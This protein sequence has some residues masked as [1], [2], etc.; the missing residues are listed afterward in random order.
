MTVRLKAQLTRDREAFK[1]IGLDGEPDDYDVQDVDAA[2]RTLRTQL[3]P[4]KPGG[5]AAKFDEARKAHAAARFYSL[6]PKPC[7]T[8]KGSG[9]REVPS[10]RSFGAPLLMR[11]DTC[12]GGGQR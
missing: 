11:C 5:D 9:K 10:N 7:Q 1:V 3:H 2:W 4:D 8:C 6:Q 12:G